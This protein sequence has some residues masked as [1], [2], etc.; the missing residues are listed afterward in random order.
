MLLKPINPKP[1][2]FCVCVFQGVGTQGLATEQ[3]KP[4]TPYCT[5]STGLGVRLEGAEGILRPG[6]LG[7]GV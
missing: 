1:R 4:C 2:L 7:L 6:G 3:L 5:L